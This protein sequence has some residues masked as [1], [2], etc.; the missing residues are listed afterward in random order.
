MRTLQEEL[1]YTADF[2]EKQAGVYDFLLKSIILG[3][4]GLKAGG[5]GIARGGKWLYDTGKKGY[6]SKLMQ[7][8]IIPKGL[9]IG[10]A[11]RKNL[12]PAAKMLGTGA[13]GTLGAATTIGFGVPII[14]ESWDKGRQGPRE[15]AFV[16]KTFPTAQ[17][18]GPNYQTIQANPTDF[19]AFQNSVYT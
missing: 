19:T 10:K 1:D 12:W 8:Q 14:R 7:T 13:L 6:N 15:L 9:G 4:K 18:R 11:I 2:M 5:K 3:G 16:K 17:S